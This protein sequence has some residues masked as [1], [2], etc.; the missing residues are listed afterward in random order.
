MYRSRACKALTLAFAL[1]LL[2]VSGVASAQMVAHASHHAHHKAATH[3]T[4]VCVWMCAAGQVLAAPHIII[5]ATL[6]PVAIA[7]ADW[8]DAPIVAFGAAPSTRGPPSPIV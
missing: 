2:V 7:R 3:G 8:P 6:G 4:M 1:S 5:Q